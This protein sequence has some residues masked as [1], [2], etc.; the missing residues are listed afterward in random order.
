MANPNYKRTDV[1]SPAYAEDLE[2]KSDN[3][4]IIPQ[5]VVVPL[6]MI[7]YA[8]DQKDLDGARSY[9]G[10]H[11][12][13]TLK[14]NQ[15]VTFQIHQWTENVS[16]DRR[17]V[18]PVGEWLIAERIIVNR[19]EYIGRKE[20]VEV[21]LWRETMDAFVLAATGVAGRQKSGME[22]NFGHARNE[23]IMVDFE[24]PEHTYQRAGGP[25]VKETT[26]TEVLILSHD[27]K[28]VAHDSETDKKNAE[29][30]ERLEAWRKRIKDIK[31]QK[32]P[33]NPFGKN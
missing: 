31:E 1:A 15:Q 16:P 5:P 18:T 33:V 26:T 19:G 21:P 29:R 12:N 25:A 7:C 22:V 4:F 8:V 9:R 23:A 3:W 13:E 17:V 10:I 28:L 11:A 30:I 32:P 24:G 2:L 14:K 27:G 20:R 6:E